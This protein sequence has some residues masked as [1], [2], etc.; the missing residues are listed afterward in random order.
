[1]LVMRLVRRV[2]PIQVTD[3]ETV[4][5]AGLNA[6][7]YGIRLVFFWAGLFLYGLIQT[8][9]GKLPIECAIP[10]GVFLLLFIGIF[11]WS[12]YRAKRGIS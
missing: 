6:V 10:A 8:V 2:L 12:V 11:G 1:M 4:R 7:R 5:V 9:R 3:T